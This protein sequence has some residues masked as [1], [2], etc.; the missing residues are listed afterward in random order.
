M[1]CWPTEASAQCHAR[2]SFDPNGRVSLRVQNSSRSGEVR[3]FVSIQSR[4]IATS[5][6]GIGTERCGLGIAEFIE[7]GICFGDIEASP[8][9]GG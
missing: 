1:G 7:R 8:T 6:G 9:V 2:V 5:T 4:K 3:C